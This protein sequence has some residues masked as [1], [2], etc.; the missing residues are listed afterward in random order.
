MAA[1]RLRV[2]ET[3]GVS[4]ASL[5]PE[6]IWPKSVY[7]REHNIWLVIRRSVLKLHHAVSVEQK[8]AH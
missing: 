4:K 7:M 5:Q 2:I 1:A 3:T 6:G 8:S